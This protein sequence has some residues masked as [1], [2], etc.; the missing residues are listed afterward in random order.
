MNQNK[1]PFQKSQGLLKAVLIEDLPDID[2]PPSSI[3]QS[4]SGNINYSSPNSVTDLIRNK[5]SNLYNNFVMTKVGQY[6]IHGI[7]KA[8]V[9]SLTSNSSKF[10]V[11][12]VPNDNIP[13]G[14]E[15]L[16]SSLKWISFQTRTTTNIL[17]EFGNITLQPQSYHITAENNISDIVNLVDEKHSHFLYTP[18]NLPIKIEVLKLKTDDSFANKGTVTSALELYQ[19]VLSIT[20]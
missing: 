8:L 3:R 14:R 5:I 12:I 6:E 16:L 15:K 13:I 17:K 9:N 20:N 1:K 19:T 2:I 10:I 4:S 18:D 11:A 7:Y